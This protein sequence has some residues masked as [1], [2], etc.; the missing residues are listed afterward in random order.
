[1]LQPTSYHPLLDAL[2]LPYAAAVPATQTFASLFE[3]RAGRAFANDHIALRSAS[4]AGGIAMFEAVFSSL[5]WKTQN[6]YQ[7]DDVHLRAIYM[8]QK[9]MPRIF[10]S[11]LI[12][13]RCSANLQHAL[14]EHLDVVEP[15]AQV[16]FFSR[17]QI[18]PT[19]ALVKNIAKE[20]QY[21]AWLLLFHRQVNH[22]T[23]SIDD[24]EFWQDHLEE[25]GVAMKRDI[26][27]AR[28]A[29]GEAGLRQTATQAAVVDV[30]VADGIMRWPYAYFEIA[31]RKGG[32]DGFLTPQARQL[33]DMTQAPTR[34][35]P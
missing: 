29:A 19:Q 33:F 6:S 14:S 26:E 22:F 10:I 5:G 2:W 3:R 23:A 34:N 8:S 30:P 27:G 28:I 16:G 31:E 20:S 21:A 7:F 13:D 9:G 18:R 17:S 4:R 25:N 12:E 35:R 11:E 1:M 15:D 24:V 32:F